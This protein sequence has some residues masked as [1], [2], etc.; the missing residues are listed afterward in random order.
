MPITTEA[1]LRAHYGEVSPTAQAKGIDHL[2]KHCINFI[3]RSPFLILSTSDG[4]R[5]DTSPKGDKPGFVHI[6]DGNL[7]IPDWPGNKRL[8]GM[9]NILSVPWVGT[10]FMVPN[11]RETL[12]VNGKASILIDEDVR[13]RFETR[14]KLPVAVLKIEP[15]E[16]FLHC[17]KA[18]IRSKLWETDTW[19]D[20][21]VIPPLYVMIKD[22]ANLDKLPYENAQAM[23]Q[24]MEK[25]LY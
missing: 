25:T 12:R 6:V 3:E 13:K 24:A 8:D 5:A 21:S 10:L 18:F 23:E 2:D 20:R 17:S 9:R 4:V 15:E 22:H 11:I 7:L 1:E 14:G 19:P 16:V